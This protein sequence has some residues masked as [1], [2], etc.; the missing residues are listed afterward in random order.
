MRVMSESLREVPASRSHAKALAATIVIPLHNEEGLL[1]T[2]VTRL[3]DEFGRFRIESEFLLCENGSRDRTQEIA[4]ALSLKH[5]NVRVVTLAK[6][7]YGAAV[8]EG[9]LRAAADHVIIFNAD[10]WSCAFFSESFRMLKSGCDMV[11]GSK[12]L[13]PAND[14]RPAIRRFITFGF[15]VFLK[16]VFGL[17]ASDT[18]GMKALR[19]SSLLP[20]IEKCRTQNEVFDTEVVLRAQRAGLRIEELPVVVHDLRPARLALLRRVPSTFR[21]LITI[22]HTL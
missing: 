5:D 3:V 7:S 14:R 2:L 10:L 1:S 20:I 16:A 17:R 18:H 9:I 13:V 21:D 19:R 11:I 4:R 12:R 15:N 6:A 8:R 22:A